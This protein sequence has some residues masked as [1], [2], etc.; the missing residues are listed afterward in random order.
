[1][2]GASG[3]VPGALHP[4]AAFTP[5]RSTWPTRPRLVKFTLEPERGSR[6]GRTLTSG[7]LAGSGPRSPAS[8]RARHLTWKW[9]GPC[10]ALPLR[11]GQVLAQGSRASSRAPGLGATQQQVAGS[12]GLQG[13][14]G[15]GLTC[16]A[17]RPPGANCSS[18]TGEK[19]RGT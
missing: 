8:A 2:T 19:R 1:M 7:A 14:R 11:P 5:T 12:P 4:G 13:A 18:E 9:G 16:G 15:V 10:V 6:R 3:D 17:A